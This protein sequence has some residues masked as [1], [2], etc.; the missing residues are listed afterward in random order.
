MSQNEMHCGTCSLWATC[1]CKA[2]CNRII[3]VL[4]S[5]QAL[6][7][8]IKWSWGPDL[9]HGPWVWH[10]WFTCTT[11]LEY[12]TGEGEP[13]KAEQ[14]LFNTLWYPCTVPPG[15]AVGAVWRVGADR[16]PLP[17]VALRGSGPGLPAEE[18]P[19]EGP[20]IFMK[21][22]EEHSEPLT[23]SYHQWGGFLCTARWNPWR[24][25]PHWRVQE[26][27]HPTCATWPQ[28]QSPLTHWS[29]SI[30]I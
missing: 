10:P 22:A 20:H 29:T 16:A 11:P 14:G 15:G 2:A 1:F 13:E 25:L 3:N 12:T 4:Y 26:P 7:G 27:Q 24:P 8:R 18:G 30:F 5:L 23:C 21:D 9:A 17:A 19:E 28:D 6:A